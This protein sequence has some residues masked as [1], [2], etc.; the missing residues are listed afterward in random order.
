MLTSEHDP[1][2][3]R[4]VSPLRKHWLIE[5]CIVYEPSKDEFNQN[6][7]LSKTDSDSD[8]SGSTKAEEAVTRMSY[9][10]LGPIEA[11]H[12]IKLTPI[13]FDLCAK[14]QGG[15]CFGPLY[16]SR[17]LRGGRIGGKTMP[18]TEA[19]RWNDIGEHLGTDAASSHDEQAREVEMY[20][21][22]AKKYQ[23]LL[24]DPIDDESVCIIGNRI[25]ETSSSDEDEE[26]RIDIVRPGVSIH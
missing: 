25:L 7:S 2:V 11:S 15:V 4:N 12:I 13:I 16:P 20:I 3:I 17:K 8:N 24:E 9:G 14:R 19:N 26:I 23:K 6:V 22:H 5:R 18:E 21:E 1:D 10:S